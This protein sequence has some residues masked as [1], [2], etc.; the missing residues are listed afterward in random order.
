M[1]V[2]RAVVLGACVVLAG[3]CTEE[4]APSPAAA[5][6]EALKPAWRKVETPVPVGKKLKCASLLH[7]DQATAAVGRQLEVKDE[8]GRDPEATAVC[9]LMTVGKPPSE[10][11][12]E[13]MLAKNQAL[14]LLP[15]DELC[16]I[17]LY[18]WSTYTVPD[19]KK[20]CEEKKEAPSTEIGA[21]SCVQEVKAGDKTRY[22]ITILDDDT[23]C[24]IVVHSGPGVTDLPTTKTCA[25]V[26]VE[27]IS[28]E[29][30]K[31]SP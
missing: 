27:Q 17:S 15:G 28:T 5:A 19:L 8:S 6:K 25:K 26:A 30:L 18:C 4:D 12:Q 20:K 9:R 13:R 22:N 16:Q 21:L 7:A 14:G 29:G 24:K 23:R 2:G 1:I 10:K 31:S 3:A 11:E